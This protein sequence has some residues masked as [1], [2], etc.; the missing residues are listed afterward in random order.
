M[1]VWLIV[2]SIRTNLFSVYINGVFFRRLGHRNNYWMNILSWRF[3]NNLLEH[4]MKSWIWRTILFVYQH[5][6]TFFFNEITLVMS[7]SRTET[8][9]KYW[10]TN[11]HFLLRESSSG[12]SFKSWN[13]WKTWT[14]H[15]SISWVVI[16]WAAFIFFYPLF[17]C[18]YTYVYAYIYI[19]Y[20]V[21]SHKVWELPNSRIWLTETDIDRGL[22][23]PI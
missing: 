18:M 11:R 7:A 21:L 5:L 2:A 22:D 10:R 1:K 15:G 19:F 13:I 3:K 4:F 12:I 17:V 20:M 23:F 9:Y 8:G 6:F 16:Y 14:R